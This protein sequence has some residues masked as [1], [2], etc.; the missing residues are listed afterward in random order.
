LDAVFVFF[1]LIAKYVW[2]RGEQL[3]VCLI[4]FQ[5]AFPSVNRALLLRKLEVMGVSSRFRR[6]L[7]SIFVGNTFAIRAGAKVTE[8]FP[9]TTGLREGSVLS[10]L[11]FILFMSDM[12]ERV[13]RPF[14][15][16]EFLKRDPVL[17]RIPIPGLLYADDLVLLCLTA[18]LLRERLQRLSWYADDNS[19]TVNVG[20]CEVV[21]FGSK[22]CSTKFRYK[23]QMI[24]LRTSCKY[25]GVWLDADMSGKTLADAISHKFRAAVPVFFNLCR[26]L[27]M[28]RIDL[29]HR[30]GNS[31]VFSLLYGC[32]FLRRRDVVEECEQA[33]WRGVRAFYGLPNGVSTVTLRLMFPKVNLVDKVVLS[34]FSLLH[35]G[36]QPLKTLFPEALVCDRGFLFDKHR[37]GFS[38]GLYEW[39]EQLG[40][41]DVFFEKELS[42]VR[43]HIFESRQARK[44]SDWADFSIMSST[45][46]AAAIFGSPDK[47][48]GLMLE[49]S[50][51]GRTG[52]RAVLLVISGA[53]SL[54]YCKTRICVLCGDTSSYSFAHFLSCQTLGPHLTQSLMLCVESD[55]LRGAATLLLSR[56]Q[57]F[58]HAVRGSELTD[59][60]EEL[61]SMLN[62]ID[63]GENELPVLA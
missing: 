54:S 36:S 13:L 60:E 43:G 26:R 51:Y 1:A 7:N 42:I 18:D 48:Y 4:D 61:F 9:M 37:K 22:A 40:L 59:D 14:G 17:N 34:K 12:G 20:K 63:A 49:V 29:V 55:D 58:V 44:E 23:K 31:L 56:F 25:L 11:L 24:P 6:G 53:L 46:C 47:F 35:R 16:S 15:G 8:E 45:T 27:R 32:E 33:W 30:L 50:R 41:V 38:Q 21:V 57:V 28:G 52:V 62:E 2:V 3:F 5:K 19:L 39:C 10:P